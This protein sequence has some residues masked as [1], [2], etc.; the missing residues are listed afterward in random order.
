MWSNKLKKV[1]LLHCTGANKGK[2]HRKNLPLCVEW[3]RTNRM[4]KDNE[5][6]TKRDIMG[7][8]QRWEN[9]CPINSDRRPTKVRGVSND[10]S[11][12]FTPV[13]D[14]NVSMTLS[15]EATISNEV[16][17]IMQPT[18]SKS[19]VMHGDMWHQTEYKIIK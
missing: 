9:L 4:Q 18:D 16:S 19:A 3:N 12:G 17:F 10:K 5:T 7:R 1:Y 8:N 6:N 13:E 11:T 2:I 14:V 15:I